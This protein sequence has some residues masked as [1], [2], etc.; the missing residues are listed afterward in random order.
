MRKKTKI[1]LAIEVLEKEKEALERVVMDTAIQITNIDCHIATLEEVRPKRKSG[2]IKHNDT[3]DNIDDNIDI[4]KE[5][6]NE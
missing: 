4:D 3:I 1:V 5:K 6:D 2:K